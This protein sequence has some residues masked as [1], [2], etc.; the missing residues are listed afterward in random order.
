[1][2]FLNTN[3]C[4]ILCNSFDRPDQGALAGHCFAQSRKFLPY[5]EILLPSYSSKSWSK[6]FSMKAF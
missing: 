3:C 4:E 1:M 6:P 2:L 5:W